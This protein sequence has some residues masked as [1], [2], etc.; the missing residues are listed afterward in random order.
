M[1]AKASYQGAAGEGE[2]LALLPGVH[3]AF[4]TVY[5]HHHWKHHWDMVRFS[6]CRV[7]EMPSVPHLLQKLLRWLC[8]TGGITLWAS[9]PLMRQ[10]LK[11][12]LELSRLHFIAFVC[13]NAHEI[14]KTLCV[15]L[16]LVLS[17]C[18]VSVMCWLCMTCLPEKP[19]A[20]F[21]SP[22]QHTVGPP[23][24][25]GYLCWHFHGLV[26]ILG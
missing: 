14:I 6:S 25:A 13:Y 10:H 1:V 8:E 7:S 12:T 9:M 22:P 24:A 3:Y 15:L 21:P 26:G 18:S 17:P 19:A 23:R 20:V 4:C 16:G 2:S 5:H 11:L